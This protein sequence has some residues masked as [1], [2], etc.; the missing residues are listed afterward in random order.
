MVILGNTYF[1]MMKSPIQNL[2]SLQLWMQSAY[3]N[4]II[5]ADLFV[6]TFFWLGSFLAS[7]QLLMRMSINEGRLPS[8]KLK[9]VLGRMVRLLPLY[10]FTMIFF[11]R[12][13]VLFGGQGPMF[14]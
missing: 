2:E 7:Y 1:F 3:F 9:L 14:Y 4:I 5:S 10:F 13:V 8:S 6:D 11:W 12:F